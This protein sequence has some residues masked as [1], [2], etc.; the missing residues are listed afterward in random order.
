LKANDV[1]TLEIDVGHIRPV[2]VALTAS[3]LVVTLLMPMGIHWPEI[4]ED[5]RYRQDTARS[6]HRLTD[7]HVAGFFFG[8][9][10]HQH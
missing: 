10:V 9:A 7:F 6:S 5:L 3:D 2:S 4:D 8:A 1:S